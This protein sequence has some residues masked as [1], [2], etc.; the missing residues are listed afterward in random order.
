M[1]SCDV[2]TKGF[3]KREMLVVLN[4]GMPIYRDNKAKNVP[5]LVL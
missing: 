3:G 5:K 1:M 2:I 4:A